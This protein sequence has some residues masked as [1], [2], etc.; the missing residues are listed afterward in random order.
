M[1]M[2][3]PMTA[4][5]NILEVS[6]LSVSYG[7][8]KAVSNLTL[9]IGRGSVVGLVGE[10]GSGKSTTLKA[11]AGLLGPTGHTDAGDIRFDGTE[12][13]GMGKG[14]RAH[15]RGG[16]MAYVVQDP[17][18]SLDPLFT[19][20]NQF[21]ECIRA[22]RKMAGAEIESLEC[23][24]LLNMGFDNPRRVLKLRPFELSGGMCQ[25]VILAMALACNCQL[26]LADEPTSALD[27]V[28]QAQII[29]LMRK[30]CDEHGL[31]ILI[32]S[33]NMGVMKR[34][35]DKVG[36]MYRGHLVEFGPADKVFDSPLHPYTRDLIAA[37]P[38]NDATAITAPASHSYED[39]SL[40]LHE[41][42]R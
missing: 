17:T 20:K 25:R 4:N 13:T 33:H 19:V 32:V 26:L 15:L 41:E 27:V 1:T 30:L 31:S 2:K 3:E 42:V 14:Q 10:S 39:L 11:I 34:I 21:D 38:K 36:V 24:M 6:N 35:A 22:H 28:S 18:A 40:M 7:N 37:I 23:E 8:V 9:E 5:D 12:L 16:K 29:E